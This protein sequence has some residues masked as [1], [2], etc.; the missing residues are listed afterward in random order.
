MGKEPSTR[1]HPNGHVSGARCWR[2]HQTCF[3]C[4]DGHVLH[5]WLDGEGTNTKSTP[6]WAHFWCSAPCRIEEHQTDM[7]GRVSPPRHVEESQTDATGRVSPLVMSNRTHRHN[8]EGI[9]S[10]LRPMNSNRCDG[11]GSPSPSHRVE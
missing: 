6:K 5:V 9:P 1:K 4:P 8:R 10:L 2:Q 3:T 11:E 7:T